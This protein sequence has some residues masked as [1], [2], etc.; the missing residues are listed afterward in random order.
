[1]KYLELRGDGVL[2]VGGGDDGDAGGG[3]GTDEGEG[4]VRGE[5]RVVVER[6]AGALQFRKGL[7]TD[8]IWG[9]RDSST[10]MASSYMR[11]G[12]DGLGARADFGAAVAAGAAVKARAAA[13]VRRARVPHLRRRRSRK[14]HRGDH[15]RREQQ[16]GHGCD[17]F[18]FSRLLLVVG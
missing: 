13:A 5:P 6:K 17:A 4:I 12:V 11:G 10:T 1:M 8:K 9:R 2:L 14:K 7:R 18:H 16:P 3:G 15:G